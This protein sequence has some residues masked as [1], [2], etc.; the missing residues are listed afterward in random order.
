MIILFDSIDDSIEKVLEASRLDGLP[1]FDWLRSP[2]V[3]T[4]RKACLLNVL[5]VACVRGR[6]QRPLID[7]I[8]FVAEVSDERV[9]AAMSPRTL[10][11]LERCCLDPTLPVY[12]DVFPIDRVHRDALAHAQPP[13]Q[14]FRAEGSPSLQLVVSS[15]TL[16]WADLD[17]DLGN[18]LQD[19]W[20]ILKHWGEL[21]RRGRTNHLHLYERLKKDPVVR[22]FLAYRLE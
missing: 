5:A 2:T 10:D 14:N 7:L 22:P 12:E 6:V 17:L 21:L 16:P 15:G 4:N 20:S 18:P 3:E 19:V 8:A 1:A 11:E 13:L 9:L